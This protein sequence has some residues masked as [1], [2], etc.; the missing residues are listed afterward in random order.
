MACTKTTLRI[1]EDETMFMPR[2]NHQPQTVGTSKPYKSPPPSTEPPHT[3][4]PD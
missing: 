3:I 4:L 2:L 1:N